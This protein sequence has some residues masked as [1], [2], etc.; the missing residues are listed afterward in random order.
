MGWEGRAESSR[1]ILGTRTSLFNYSVLHS[2]PTNKLVSSHSELSWCWNKPRAT[3]DSLDSPWPELGGSQHLPSYNILCV[4]PPH[5]HPNGTFSRDSPSGVPKLPRFGL[6][7]IWAFITSR[8]DLRLGWGLKQTCN[9]PWELSNGVLHYTCTH[10]R[11]GS[12]PNF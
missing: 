7:G 6:P 8:S 4:S 1:I 5:L 2:K 9:S 3:L 11:I 12:I 10:T